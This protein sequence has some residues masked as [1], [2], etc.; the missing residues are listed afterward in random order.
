MQICRMIRAFS[1]WKVYN[2]AP[3]NKVKNSFPMK[4]CTYVWAFQKLVYEPCVITITVPSCD[5]SKLVGVDGNSSFLTSSPLVTSQTLK[6]KRTFTFQSNWLVIKGN[7]YT[8]WTFCHFCKE[9]IFCDFLI[10]YCLLEKETLL[11]NPFALRMAKT[12]QSFGHSKCKRVKR[13]NLLNGGIFFLFKL[14]SIDKGSKIILSELPTLQSYPFSFKR[15]G[16]NSNL[17]ISFH[18][19]QKI[20]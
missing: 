14:L 8:W 19:L 20:F 12:Q 18:I 7:R 15:K 11:L 6:K 5:I 17:N 13:K 16:H 10:E 3:F 2:D 4:L 1:T 9:D